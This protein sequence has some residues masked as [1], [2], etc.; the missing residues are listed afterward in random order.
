[1][2]KLVFA[3]AA[4]AVALVSCTKGGEQEKDTTPAQLLSFEILKADN[5]F[6]D[7]DYF[8]ELITPNMVIR[9]PGGGMDKSFKATIK[10][11][12]FDK[13]YVNGAAVELTDASAKVDFQGKF[14][15]DIEVVN[16]KS[17]KSAAYEVKI[18]KILQLVSKK[19]ATMPASDGMVY[20]STSYKAAIN[21]KT[22]EMWVA[23]S[24]TPTGGVKNIGVK[25]YSNNAFAQVGPEGIVPAP[26]EGS[27]IAVST[28]CS[29]TFDEQGNAYILYYGGDVKNSL[30]MRKFDGAE[31]TLVGKAGISGKISTAWGQLPSIY[32]DDSG[33]PGF[34]YL[35]SAYAN[36][37]YSYDGT[38]WKDGTISGFPG[39]KEDES[40]G[41]NPGIFYN[42]PTARLNGK[43]YAFWT[44]NWYGL[45]VYEMS[46]SAWTQTSIQD[47]MEQG[48]KNMLPG[49]MATAIKNGKILLLATNQ[50]AAQEQIYEFDGSKLTK[51][52]AAF[53]IPISSG[54]SP[55]PVVFGVNPVDGQV[56]VVK[57]DDEKKPWF[58]VMNA[59][60]GWEDFVA[61]EEG[62]ASYG[63]L[64][65]GFDQ[66]GN[67][68]VVYPDDAKGESGFPLYSIGLEDDILPE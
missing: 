21:P 52:G 34:A 67:A 53:A 29:L 10:V 62:L 57:L 12:E 36:G 49:N 47:Y 16:T 31:W 55:N 26:T 7:K 2:K 59:D 15:V 51:Y 5:A 63:G 43:L 46:G 40:R 38:D 33:N 27:A 66:K 11:G 1:M 61:V 20:T 65:M 3:L 48:E 44:A 32:F 54:G 19:V 8:A 9:V 14:A 13:L 24:F 56:L 17:S 39:F 6:L 30:S 50:V 60:G 4:L 23:Y 45:Y 25:K 37:L 64:A 41:S 18:G 22:G 35:T 58:S 68:L 42:G 28:V